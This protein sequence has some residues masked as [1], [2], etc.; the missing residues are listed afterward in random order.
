MQ[1]LFEIFRVDHW[2][3]FW[4][5]VV[6]LLGQ[7]L[8]SMRFLVQWI[9]SERAQQVG[10]ADRLLVLLARRRRGAAQPTRST[11]ATR[12][13]C[14]A[15][16]PASSSTS[17]NLWLIHAAQA[18]GLSARAFAPRPRRDR[19]RHALA[20]GAAAVRQ[21]R[22]LR[23]RRAILVLGPGARLGLLLQAAADRLD[24]AALDRDRR[25]TR[26]FWIR[27]P[28]PLI[29][30]ATAVVVALIGRRLFGAA[31]RR[32][33]RARPSPAS[34]AWRSAACS[35]RPTRRCSSA[36]RWR[37]WRTLH[38]AE[39]RSLG[40]AVVLGAAVGRRAAGEIRDDLLPALAPRWPPCSLPRARIGWR[41]AGG[42]GGGGAA[43]SSRRT[44]SGTRP[45]ISPRCSTPPTT[46]T[47]RAP[48]LDLA[49]LAGVLGRAV[50]R[51]R[52]GVLRRLPRRPRAGS[53]RRRAG[54]ILALM[55]LPI[56]AIVSVQAL[57]LGRQ[58][59]LGGRGAPR[60]AACSPPPCCAPR[61]RAAGGS[62][63]RS[64]SPIT[65]ALPVAAVFADRWRIGSATWCSPA[66]SARPTSAGAPP[67]IARDAG[68]RHPGQRQPRDARRLLLHPARLAGSR[69]M[70]SR[71]RASRRTTTPRSTRCRPGRATCSS[72]PARPAARRAAARRR[73]ARGRRAGTPEH[74]FATGEIHAFRV[75]RALLVPRRLSG[76]VRAPRA[77]PWPST[78]ATRS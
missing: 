43:R 38:L 67:T 53:A 72:S 64:T 22:P 1:T 8:F 14:S 39:R 41:D 13:S 31:G 4:W 71:S 19:P 3:E 2:G 11:A 18:R 77:D 68:P 61:P 76:P 40:W 50:R 16:P 52:A 73:R 9:M 56:F 27:L 32:H 62:A 26:A 75:P 6:G 29:H 45:T 36:S 46:P 49:G 58:R 10:D 54:A 78:S 33:R 57:R 34:R 65:A 47:G 69:S 24:P 30:A 21:R 17:R 7:A 42:R 44:S 48:R 25:A 15:S 20:G 66:T 70:P 23:R 74:G 5:V 28:L 55:S 60:G 12:C 59:Q 37:C 35:S 63:S 51:R